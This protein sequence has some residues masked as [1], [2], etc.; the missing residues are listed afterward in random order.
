MTLKLHKF[1]F[2][3][4]LTWSL[5]LD[6]YA[7]DIFKRKFNL[8]IQVL[9]YKQQELLDLQA[10]VQKDLDGTIDEL[11]FYDFLHYMKDGKKASYFESQIE[12][13]EFI[14][15]D[16]KKRMFVSSRYTNI[17]NAR[18]LWE[19]LC[20]GKI[21]WYREYFPVV[22]AAGARTIGSRDFFAKEG[23]E[24]VSGARRKKKLLLLT[25][26]QPGLISGIKS[27]KSDADI[28]EIL[29]IYNSK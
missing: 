1:T 19:I 26:D 24:P 28:L 7:Q 17:K 20:A 29:K 13:L 16:G 15:F 23:K 4:L 2:L 10:I 18:G 21:T 27:S 9:I 25:S 3:V 14:D 6:T 8:D 5:S 22:M 11:S 12:H